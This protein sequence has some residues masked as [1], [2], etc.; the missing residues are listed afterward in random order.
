M[1]IK[2]A[3]DIIKEIE[4]RGQI[5]IPEGCVTGEEFE[6]WL[7]RDKNNTEE[8]KRKPNQDFIKKK[9]EENL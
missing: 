2:Y 1:P 9:M 5:Q 4:E 7:R 8:A 3:D 6:E